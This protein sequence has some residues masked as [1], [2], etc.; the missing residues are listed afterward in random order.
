MQPH[1]NNK[2]TRNKINN[3]IYLSNLIWNKNALYPVTE[4][5]LAVA[6]DRESTVA[7]EDLPSS[8]PAPIK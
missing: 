8:V 4:Q 3:N 6:N 1:S 5:D 2:K 7:E